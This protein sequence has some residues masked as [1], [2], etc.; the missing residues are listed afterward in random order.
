MMRRTYHKQIYIILFLSLFL[1]ACPGFIIN[2]NILQADKDLLF[3]DKAKFVA[4]RNELLVLKMSDE[5]INISNDIQKGLN[6]KLNSLLT[7]AKG[8]QSIESEQYPKWKANLTQFHKE[9]ELFEKMIKILREKQNGS[10]Y[11]FRS[12]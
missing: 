5:D 12:N 7:Q 8:I 3:S 6:L 1:A 11:T 2:K 4:F 9:M 10:S